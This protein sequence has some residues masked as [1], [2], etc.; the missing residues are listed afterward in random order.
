MLA[1]QQHIWGRRAVSTLR[2]KLS[3]LSSCGRKRRECLYCHSCF[4][5][6]SLYHP[7]SQWKEHTSGW[8]LQPNKG[9]CWYFQSLQVESGSNAKSGVLPP[10]HIQISRLFSPSPSRLITRGESMISGNRRSAP[11]WNN[12]HDFDQPVVESLWTSLEDKLD[13]TIGRFVGC[14][15]YM[16][17]NSWK[18]HVNDV[19]LKWVLFSYC[20]SLHT[21]INEIWEKE[22][23]V[24][25]W[26]NTDK[27]HLQIASILQK[28]AIRTVNSVL[29]WSRYPT[30][31]LKSQSLKF[32][33]LVDY[34]TVQILYISRH[35]LLPA[36]IQTWVNVLFNFK[37]ISKTSW[38]VWTGEF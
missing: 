34:K 4:S 31:F 29:V 19:G 22:R 2:P 26:G 3:V 5:T 14:T 38:A 23:R 33:D 13:S 18:P 27:S 35:N 28:R 20:K 17:A 9:R 1:D 36:N 7:N 8:I 25:V 6:I 37:R 10:S 30:L 16:D 32:M 11:W 21:P 12:G 15:S 24:E